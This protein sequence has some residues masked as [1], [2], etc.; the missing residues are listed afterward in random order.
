MNREKF[1]ELAELGLL[2]ERQAEALYRRQ[3]GQGRQ[4]A[5]DEMDI[6][7]SNLDNAEREAREKIMRAKNT[8]TAAKAIDAGP[9]ESI[10]G[11][12]A[13]CNKSAKALHPDPDDESDLTEKRM[14]CEDCLPEDSDL[15][16]TPNV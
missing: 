9:E 1:I 5:A 12:C 16:K 11:I 7:T 10:T 6:S 13:E 2:T 14:I 4:E 3:M 8:L 15:R